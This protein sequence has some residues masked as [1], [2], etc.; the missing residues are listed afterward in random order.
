[1]D[2]IAEIIEGLSSSDSH[3]RNECEKTL[4][5]YKKNDLNNTV[6]SILK[7]LK[8]HKDS[9]VR[10]QCAIL[11]RNIF[12]VYIKS[13]N[14]ETEEKE[15]NENSVLNS[16]EENYW[17]LLPDNL[18]NIVKSELI[19]NIGTETDKMVRNNICNNII[20]LSSKLLLNNQWPELITVTFEFC[21]SNNNDVL[22]S[23]YKILGGVLSCVTDEL[24]GKHEIIS[25][26]CM[27]GLNASNVQVRG[28]CINLISCIV[29]D[30][31]SSLVKS[32]QSCIP[33]ILQSLSLMAK[34]S[35]SD[36]SVLEECEKVLQSIGKMIDYNAKF[37]SKHIS[38]LCDI[39]FSIC[40]KDE[41]ELN[42][43]FDNSL[44]SLSIEALVTIPE[45]RPKMALSVP[46][47]VDKII[48]LSMLFML[49]INNDCFNEWMNSIKE[50][51]DDSQELYDIGEES[52]DRVG[53]A[54]SEIEEAE[55]IHILF[56]KV[57]EF[58]MKNTWEHKYVGIMAIAQ[59]I[60]YLPE[61]EI[62]EQLEHVIKM[63]L[64]VL[65]DQDVRVRYAACQAIGQISLDHQPYV[66]K[67]FYSEILP[68][69][70]NT[71]ND[72]HLRVQSHATAAF[73][74]YAEELE[75]TALLPYSDIIIDI[76]LQKLNSSNYL[77]VREQAVTAIAVIAGVIEEDF[78]KYYSTVVPMMKDIIQKAVS[79]E[80]RT[81]RGKAIECISIIGLSVGKDI[82]LEDAKECM[83]A[84][85]QIS[86]GKMD[87]DDTVKEY[88]Q[89]A[90][91]RICRALGN[92][93]YPYLS[94]IVPTILSVLSVLPKPLTDDEEDLTITMVSN[95][96][97][98]GLKTSL[99]EDQEKAL[100]LLIIII[101]VLKENY[102]EYI[103][104]TA[105]SVLPM[106][107]YELSDEIK[108]KALTA[109]SELIDAARILSE[110]TDNN[111]SMLHAILTAAAEK[112]L[113]SLSETKLDDNYEYILDVMII[114]SHGLYM[115]LQKAGA[116][117]LPEGTLKL[118]FNQVF[119]LLECSTDR[120]II[121]NQKKNNEDV[122]EDELLIID[123]EE[124]LEQNYR[125]NLL[126]ILGVLIKFH[127]TQFL[128]TCCEICIT[129]INNYLSSP[130]SEDI[131]LAL[132][133]CDDLLEFLQE[134]SV[135]LWEY[136]MN[137][138]LLNI[139]HSDDK[140]KQAACY[141][142]I[143]A[144][145]IEAFGKYANIA[146]EYLLKLI[147]QNNSN[148][149]SKEFISAIDNAVAALG[150][151]VLMHTSKFNNA[152]ELIK[153]WLNNLPIKEDDA[154]G[155]RVHK[156]LIDLVSQNHPLLFG[157]DDSNTSKIIEIF[158]TIYETDF[159]DSDCN[160]KISSL[161]N[162]LD[163]SYLNN[164]ATSALTHKQAKKLNHI[165][166]N[167]R[168]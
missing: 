148:K 116:D 41:N 86:S 140:V 162:S 17:E 98:V 92:D 147:H 153:I 88:I 118:F 155:R 150:D 47:F 35:S 128:N 161:I 70:I 137:P 80:E 12:R 115:C 59:T 64:Q 57:S 65:T 27:K 119:K 52:L 101:E 157:K 72:V 135:C 10:L 61:E 163:Q 127:P 113:K 133:V 145:K 50:G 67:E 121:Y 107:N 37:F 5:F 132:Y 138:L 167:N 103:Q 18:K 104:A 20:D 66:Q 73:V 2:K 38:N 55:F 84:L 32:V 53:K 144:T 60:E 152:E 94:N 62:E 7:L 24:E 165:L 1:M 130:N 8:S 122:D 71:M 68:A 164:L 74:N 106:L 158:L 166:N 110:K 99:L 100:D 49:D 82:F 19:S 112:V 151:V 11:I 111:K 36:I 114:E 43:D 6:L 44:K 31:S 156:N 34:N 56:N 87:P 89:E 123:R 96:Q 23:G 48:H 134:N 33:L 9:Q 45:R 13:T 15:K 120:R 136:F 126:D 42:Y 160:K 75:K 69:L 146:V 30:N 131:A 125:T 39:L 14:V 93:F 109:V 142:V 3:I 22:I 81:C 108:Q 105:T 168:K 91:G 26:I 102:K 143:Q 149:K 79:E 16:E 28:E 141:G 51:K 25:S 63:L 76:L 29:E 117:V 54:F 124:E 58:L 85:L 159:S 78:L 97:Y 46:H 21:N 129:F 83:N 139:N 40:M 4:N 77:L 90:I 154:E 95:G